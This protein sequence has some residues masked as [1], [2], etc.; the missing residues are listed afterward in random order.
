[1]TVSDVV[2]FAYIRVSLG[3]QDFQRQKFLIREYLNL[4]SKL[5]NWF[6][7]KGS[8]GSKPMGDR[9]GLVLC[10]KAA[11]FYKQKNGIGNLVISDISRLSRNPNEIKDFFNRYIANSKLS[12]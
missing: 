8:S 9:K 1:M 3:A 7:D 12:L 5:I 10:L 4:D 2:H 6:S 11:T